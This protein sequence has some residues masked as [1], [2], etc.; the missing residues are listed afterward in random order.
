MLAIYTDQPPTYDDILHL[1]PIVF[2]RHRLPA[3]PG[4]P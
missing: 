2:R 1:F 3:P 4:A